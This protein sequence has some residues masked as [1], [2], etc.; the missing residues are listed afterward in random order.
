V[1]ATVLPA[2]LTA[3]LAVKMREDFWLSDSLLGIAVAVS[4]AVATIASSPAGRL[5]DR[6]GPARGIY[7]GA[8]LALICSLAIASV[9]DSA[10][11]LI[12]ILTLGGLANAFAGPGAGALI[13]HLTAHHRQGMALGAQQAGAPLGALLA[14]LAL[15]LVAVPLGWRWAFVVAALVPIAVIVLMRSLPEAPRVSPRPARRAGTGLRP[16]HLLAL[17]AALSNL[18]ANGMIAFLVVYAVGEGMSTT[19]AGLLLAMT[20]LVAATSRVI[21]GALADV[22]RG[23][24]LVG[25][26]AL[27][28]FGALGYLLL[29][30]G[31]LVALVAGALVAGGIGWG[32]AGLM[33]LAIVRTNRDAPGAAVGI[34]MMGIF[35]GA[36]IGPFAV[37]FLAEIAS[38]TAAWLAATVVTLLA[39][40]VVVAARRLETKG[41]LRD[42]IELT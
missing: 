25:V 21:F 30:T 4:F 5:V 10:G 26:A 32:W 3:G 38:F 22:R 40:V 33:T 20:S 27:L 11:S 2:F 35:A 12:A 37:G 24:V 23:R 31:H 14:G 42:V 13:S 36:S 39:A 17:A 18:A 1:V 34:G 15:P 28:S 9:V 6:M 19:A 41:A 7:V 8:V 29:A 16:V